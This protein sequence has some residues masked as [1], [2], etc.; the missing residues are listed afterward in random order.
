I[1]VPIYET[2]SPSQIAHILGDSGAKKIFVAGTSQAR[3]V[4]R[5]IDQHQLADIEKF[6][7]T[8]AGL[9]ELT[10]AGNSVPDDAGA[11]AR[12]PATMDSPATVVYTSGPTG[13]PKGALISH[14][15]LTDG[16]V[17][18]IGWAQEFVLNTANPRLLMFL[19][20][21]HIL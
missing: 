20:L 21:A 1:S 7:L 2:S 4:S 18:I 14:G 12:K 19:P 15:H 9:A 3:A 11:T 5:A 8:E 17:D 10:T 16:A 13:T 6:D